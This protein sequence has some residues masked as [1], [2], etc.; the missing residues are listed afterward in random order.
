MKL[1]DTMC[2]NTKPK[3]KQYKL[4]DGMGMHLLIKPNGGKYWRMKYRFEGK[5]K[6][7]AIGVYPQVSLKD[8]RKKREEAKGLLANGTDPSQAKKQAK[9]EVIEKTENIFENIAR[10]WHEKQSEGWTSSHANKVLRRLEIDIFPELGKKPINEMKAPDLLGAL[11]KIEKRGALDIANRARQTCGQI[12]RYAIAIGKA[13]HD[14][15]ADL[16]GALKTAK[17]KHHSHLEESELPEF[18]YKLENYDGAKLTQLAIRFTLLTFVRT[19]EVRGAEWSEF[20]FDKKEW[21]I[22]A[23]RMKMRDKH[24]VPLST[25]VLEVLEEIR[26]YSGKSQYIFPNQNNDNKCMSENTMLYALYRMGYHSRTTIHGFRGTAST[27]LN[28]NGFKPDVI[29]RQLAHAERNGVRA[30]YNHAEY[31]SERRALMQWWSDF[32]DS[33]MNGNSN[34]ISAD[35]RRG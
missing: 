14:I 34:V 9:K 6:R 4:P 21:R 1:T 22:P 8:A 11:R 33:K 29:E 12:F 7:L 28:E 24:I 31:L 20:D 25:Q 15:S 30:A 17:T 35:F 18:L 2:K 19:G 5:E 26:P 16:R 32:V 10:E 13:E 3:E 27:L 23:E